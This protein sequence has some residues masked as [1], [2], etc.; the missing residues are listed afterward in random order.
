MAELTAIALKDLVVG[1]IYRV[2]FD[3]CC[4][5][6]SFTDEFLGWVDPRTDD[7]DLT[8]NMAKFRHIEISGWNWHATET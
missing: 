6:G 7:E 4:V 8:S 2:V 3:D 1:N 5:R